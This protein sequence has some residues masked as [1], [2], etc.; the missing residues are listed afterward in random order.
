MYAK[1]PEAA[2]YTAFSGFPTVVDG[3]AILRLKPWEERSKKQ[4]Q[5]ADELRP[6]M[7]QIAGA[8]A[9]PINPPSLGQRFRA[10]PIE[11]VIMSQV[12]LRGAVAHRRPLPRRGAQDPGHRRTCR[13]T[14]G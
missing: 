3:N 14:C 13:P 12:P 7:A 11:Y 1:V 6:Q 10:Q 9:F 5:I 4:Q 8:L 2:A